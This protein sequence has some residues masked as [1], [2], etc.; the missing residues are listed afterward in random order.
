MVY[1]WQQENILYGPSASNLNRSILA[2]GPGKLAQLLT[3]LALAEDLGSVPCTWTVAHS[4]RQL[5]VQRIQHPLQ[6]SVGTRHV[7]G[8][9][10][11]MQASTHMHTR[12]AKANKSVFFEK[13]WYMVLKHS[14]HEWAKIHISC[15][16]W[17]SHIL[18]RVIEF[19]DFKK[20]EWNSM[21]RQRWVQTRACSSRVGVFS[22]TLS[23]DD[24]TVT[25]RHI[26]STA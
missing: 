19:G 20:N 9:H 17:F 26:N 25:H 22:M 18:C 24:T 1:D 2:W 3:T 21:R 16:Y 11:C 6:A 10:I 4:Y 8:A 13:R 12:K 15:I 5:L 7:Y 23:D 14:S